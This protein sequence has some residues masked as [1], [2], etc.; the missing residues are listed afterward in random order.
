[1]KSFLRLSFALLTVLFVSCTVSTPE[2]KV[3]EGPEIKI[4][5]GETKKLNVSG[6]GIYCFS[7]P[8]LKEE[9]FQVNTV[10]EMVLEV[11]NESLS[12]TG[13]YVGKCKLVI[14][15]ESGESE[16]AV[17]VEPNYPLWEHGLVFEK[18]KNLSIDSIVQELGFNYTTQRGDLYIF[19]NISDKI[20]SFVCHD[21]NILYFVI[22]ISQKEYVQKSL[23]EYGRV[24]KSPR[25]SSEGESIS[26]FYNNAT[27]KQTVRT[28]HVVPVF[29]GGYAIRAYYC[30]DVICLSVGTIQ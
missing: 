18:V 27:V 3:N 21:H 2:F 5:V 26:I 10:S 15:S 22:P 19:D 8:Y 30:D 13:L 14:R 16:I 28:Y 29:W 4:K 9:G 24:D 23:Q 1:M 17:I 25:V 7:V 20:L 11:D 12:I 6:S